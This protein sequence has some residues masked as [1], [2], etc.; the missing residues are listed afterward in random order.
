MTLKEYLKQDDAN[1]IA[2]AAAVGV[3]PSQIYRIAAGRQFPSART[4]L[5]IQRF[6]SGVV[7]VGD[8]IK[9]AHS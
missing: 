7:T 1:S 3:H 4:A 8:L 2:L 6:T 9:E 5:A